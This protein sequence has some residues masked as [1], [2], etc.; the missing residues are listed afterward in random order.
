MTRVRKDLPQ[1]QPGS[2][3]VTA[4]AAVAAARLDY[5]CMRDA[6][7]GVAGDINEAATG[8]RQ[9]VR[10]NKGPYT[11]R[12]SR[13][14]ETA[15]TE[16]RIRGQ[17]GARCPAKSLMDPRSRRP[18]AAEA[19]PFSPVTG[20][21]PCQLINGST[22]LVAIVAQAPSNPQYP[23]P[24]T[25]RQRCGH[26]SVTIVACRT[27]IDRCAA[28]SSPRLAAGRRCPAHR[29]RTR[30][31]SPARTTRHAALRRTRRSAGS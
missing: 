23:N 6:R 27:T 13:C 29:C 5:P 3:V 17:V 9:R 22:S 28:P 30:V 4:I 21:R 25:L 2:D 15:G 24:T 16:S 8:Q 18:F 7:D 19:H 20:R 11:T 1:E 14:R 10:H 26:V 31:R 12:V